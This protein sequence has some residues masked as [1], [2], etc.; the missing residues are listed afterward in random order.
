MFGGIAMD[1]CLRLFQSLQWDLHSSPIGYPFHSG[2]PETQTFPNQGKTEWDLVSPGEL[3]HSYVYKD[4]VEVPRGVPDEFKVRNQMA[5]GFKSALFWWS[6]INK[7]V[8]WINYI[9][10]N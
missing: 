8:D 10:Y 1:L 2:I 7:N 6:T 4:A 5:A 3:F 9:H